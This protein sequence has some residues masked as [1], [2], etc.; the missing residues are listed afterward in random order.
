MGTMSVTFELWVEFVFNNPVREREWYWD[1]DFDSRW[2]ALELTDA[3]IVQYMTRLFLEP[4]VLSPYSLDQVE[5]GLWFLIGESSPGCS[6]KALLR[7]EATLP[8]RVACIRAMSGFFR[9]FILAATPQHFDPNAP[10]TGVNGAAYMWWDI[11][12]MHFYMRDHVPGGSGCEVLL[13]TLEKMRLGPEIHEAVSKGLAEELEMEIE[14]EIHQATLSVMSEVL[15]LPSE[16]CQFSALHGLGHW[17]A[18]RPQHVE[19][20]VDAFL[21][22]HKDLRPHLIEYASRARRGKVL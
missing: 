11:F 12:P 2:E 21:A 22:R 14:P 4:G 20:I 5:Q 17:H 10:L 7:K 3:V 15:D 1:E 8:E 9:N 16:T 13:S 18:E 6:G 19:Q